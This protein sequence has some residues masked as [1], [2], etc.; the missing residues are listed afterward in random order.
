M[1]VER[2]KSGLAR[3]RSDIAPSGVG[4]QPPH[5]GMIGGPHD[6]N[7]ATSICVWS[8]PNAP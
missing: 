3:A 8:V 1:I 6:R 4:H 5:S 2:V 7:F